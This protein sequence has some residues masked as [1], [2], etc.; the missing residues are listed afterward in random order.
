[1]GLSLVLR[2]FTIFLYLFI[3]CTRTTSHID[4][5]MGTL[6]FH[7]VVCWNVAGNGV[8]ECC[9]IVFFSLSLS[10]TFFSFS[11]GPFYEVPK[12]HSSFLWIWIVYSGM[13]LYNTSNVFAYRGAVNL[14][15]LSTIMLLF[16]VAKK[17]VHKQWPRCVSIFFPKCVFL[18][19]EIDVIIPFIL[20][21]VWKTEYHHLILAFVRYLICIECVH[22]VFDK[23]I[24]R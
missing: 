5:C 16:C 4:H 21:R 20:F 12:W 9:D 14:H 19:F 24:D 6:Y 2:I 18:P 8:C 23:H 22:G 3:R 7:A 1:M 10:H 15:Q 11:N 17:S 13:V